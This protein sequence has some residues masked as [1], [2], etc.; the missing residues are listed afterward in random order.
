M[1]SNLIYDEVAF[2]G[3]F[4]RAAALATV[5]LVVSVSLAELLRWIL[6]KGIGRR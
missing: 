2:S 5:L 3:N 6:V 4:G 1:Y